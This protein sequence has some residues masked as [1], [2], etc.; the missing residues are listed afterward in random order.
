[1]PPPIALDKTGAYPSI[2]P[3]TPPATAAAALAAFNYSQRLNRL[4]PIPMVDP[5]SPT[6]PN[7]MCRDPFC[8]G[9]CGPLHSHLNLFASQNSN[10]PRPSSS[11]PSALR[12]ENSPNGTNHSPSPVANNSAPCTLATCPNGCN[13]CEHQRY[14][15]ALASIYRNPAAFSGLNAGFLSTGAMAAAA[16]NYASSLAAAAVLNQ[17]RLAA[18]MAPNASGNGNVC[19][20]VLGDNHHCGKRFN[21]SEE[22]L[23]HLK[24]HTNAMFGSEINSNGR[25]SSSS[26]SP[27]NHHS[28]TSAASPSPRSVSGTSNVA[29]S[30][31]SSPNNSNNHRFHP[32]SKSSSLSATSSALS[33]PF[34]IPSNLFGLN[35]PATGASTGTAV[36]YPLTNPSHLNPNGFGTG[37][38]PTPGNYYYPFM[39]PPNLLAGR[40]GPPVPP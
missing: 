19:N 8:A 35:G 40:I 16:N 11:S 27:T 3:P 20:W 7:S 21:T 24:T 15:A 36:N 39:A 10:N 31:S 2:Y 25:L 37:L 6:N 22:L 18:A 29:K 28:P 14:L 17:Q 32:Y 33:N 9:Q 12:N 23:Q 13:R 34:S 30:P 5:S 26:A 1:M 38:P 4:F